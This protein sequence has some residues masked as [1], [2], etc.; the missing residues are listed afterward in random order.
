[1]KKLML[2][3]IISAVAVLSANVLVWDNENGSWHYPHPE[4]G[5]PMAG[6]QGMEEVLDSLNIEYEHTQMLPADLAQYSLIFVSLGSF[7][8]T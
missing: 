8:E 7:C 1:M 5:I 3:C 4:T 6:Y 2:L